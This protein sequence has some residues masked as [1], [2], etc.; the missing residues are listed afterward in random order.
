M[1]RVETL[2]ESDQALPERTFGQDSPH[3]QT[4]PPNITPINPKTIPP[5]SIP[6]LA[7]AAPLVGL[8]DAALPVAVELADKA[9]K[10]S[11]WPRLGNGALGSTAHP[12][13]VELGHATGEMAVAEAE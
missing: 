7:G 9:A 3:S 8:A 10:L 12:L 2:Q 6:P 11:V 5:T 1:K 13:A 4:I